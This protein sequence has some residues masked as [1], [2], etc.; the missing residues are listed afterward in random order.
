M[1]DKIDR[2]EAP[3]PYQITRPKDAKEDQHRQPDQ[4]EEQEKRYQKELSEKEWKKFDRRTIV[5][6]PL[7]ADK[8]AIARCLFRAVGLRSGVGTLQIDVVWKD[9]KTTQG[10]LV[11][12]AR[13]EDFIKLKKFK[14]GQQVPDE[15][16]SRGS[17]VELGIPQIITT[18]SAFPDQRS[19]PKQGPAGK[20]IRGNILSSL[21]IADIKS[22]RINWGI[23]A[24]Y[25]FLVAVIV[26]AIVFRK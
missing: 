2:P 4:R 21:K 26:L 13:L 20:S 5:I 10:A 17:A 22:R 9:G 1:I 14:P 16:W 23:V 3:Q 8:N 7:R 11:L 15:F 18:P 25:V 6:K 12:L 19:A 24:L